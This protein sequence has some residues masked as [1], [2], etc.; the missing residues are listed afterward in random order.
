MIRYLLFSGF[1]LL[2]PCVAH[3]EIVMVVHPSNPI[4]HLSGHDVQS[5]YFFKKVTWKNGVRIVPIHL[6]ARN[7]LREALSKKWLARSLGEIENF[8]LMRALSGQ[9]Q[10]PVIFTTVEE[11]KTYLSN[12]K[13]GIAYL[14][15]EDID[16]SVKAILVETPDARR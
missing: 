9:G 6:G 8:Y 5:I 15:H 12:T 10:P 4:T 11:V 1:L 7:A 16:D 2:L 14:N 13:G 3:A